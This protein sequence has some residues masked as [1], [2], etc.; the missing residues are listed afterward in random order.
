MTITTGDIITDDWISL[1]CNKTIMCA[2]V[3]V[4]TTDVNNRTK[5]DALGSRLFVYIIKDGVR[6]YGSTANVNIL[7]M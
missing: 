4:K 1:A 7:C 5:K 3:H 6:E 2:R